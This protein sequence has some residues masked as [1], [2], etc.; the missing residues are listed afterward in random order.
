VPL[1]IVG[2]GFCPTLSQRER[3]ACARWVPPNGGGRP[4]AMLA[5]DASINK[6]KKRVYKEYIN[7]YFMVWQ[8]LF[9][10]IYA[11]MN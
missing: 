7:Y 3:R 1:R 4:R 10:D 9:M 8:L 5:L 11:I 2:S 6:G